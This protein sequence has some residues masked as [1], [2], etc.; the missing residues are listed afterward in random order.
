[1]SPDK[2][3]HPRFCNE[4]DLPLQSEAIAKCTSPSSC[5]SGAIR[6]FRHVVCHCVLLQNLITPIPEYSHAL[7]NAETIG[8]TLDNTLTLVAN[9]A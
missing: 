9:H 2:C 1:M 8:V 4:A 7:L 3:P 6:I 5:F